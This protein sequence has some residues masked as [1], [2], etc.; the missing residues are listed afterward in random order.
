MKKRLVV[1]A[2]VLF[3][4]LAFADST[5][6]NQGMKVQE[7]KT[8][9]GHPSFKASESV[10]GQGTVLSVNKKTREVK[11]LAEEGD[12][13]AVTCGPE[14][15][16]F[17]KIVKGDVVKVKYT[18]TLMIHVEPE[19]S[20]LTTSAESSPSSAKPGEKPHGTETDKVKFSGVITA[21]DMAKGTVTL[22]G[23]EGNELEVRPRVKENL[24]KVKVGEVVVFNYEQTIAVSVVKVAK[25]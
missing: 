25:K 21:I 16:N 19:G 22:K 13:V 20:P 8:A 11:I 18:E 4:A 24:K 5:S 10:E 1:L 3:P 14:I 6:V 2:L 17:T 7:G 12:T 15:K 9:T 23:P